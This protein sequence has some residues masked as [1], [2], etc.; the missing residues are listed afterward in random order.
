LLPFFS[1]VDRRRALH[2]E[3][4]ASARDTFPMLLTSEVPY[5][6]QIERMS[7]VR[8]PLPASAPRSPAALVY[9]TLWEEIGARLH[10]RARAQSAA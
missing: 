8:A 2:R 3:L 10:A 4:I 5:W 6:S 7:V 9:T 1:M